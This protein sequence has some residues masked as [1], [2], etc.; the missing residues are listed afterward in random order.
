MRA[1]VAH[2]LRDAST[3]VTSGVARLRAI[4]RQ[5]PAATRASSARAAPTVASSSSGSSTRSACSARDAAVSPRSTI[6]SRPERAC[7]S[8]LA[9]GHTLRGNTPSSDCS[10]WRRDATPGGCLGDAAW[11]ALTGAGSAAPTASGSCESRRTSTRPPASGGND[12]ERRG[13][14]GDEPAA[15]ASPLLTAASAAVRNKLAT[16]GCFAMASSSTPSA[17]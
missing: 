5:Q 14:D 4:S 17:A 6:R 13:D 8:T 10:S 15:S 2:S 9:C 12:G 7:P 11:W 1:A 3:R 16:S